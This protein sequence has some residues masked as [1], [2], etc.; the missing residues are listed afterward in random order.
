MG[1]SQAS[2]P[3]QL[4]KAPASWRDQFRPEN[5]FIRKIREQ[6]ANGQVRPTANP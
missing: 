4:G 3:Y 2:D 6:F 1:N 5:D